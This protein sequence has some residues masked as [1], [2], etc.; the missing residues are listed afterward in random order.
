M[1]VE[2]PKRVDYQEIRGKLIVEQ[3]HGYEWLYSLKDMEF[4][5]EPPTKLYLCTEPEKSH[6]ADI[7]LIVVGKSYCRETGKKLSANKH[8]KEEFPNR[9]HI[10]WLRR[11]PNTPT[12]TFKKVEKKL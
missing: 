8:L 4:V 6:I 5:G 12:F 7:D 2:K 11:Q 3:A 9:L 1:I 10:N